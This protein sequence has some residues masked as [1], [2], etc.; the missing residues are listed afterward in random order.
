MVLSQRDETKATIDSL[1]NEVK[2][3]NTNFKKFEADVSFVKTG[4]NFLMKKS[5]EIEQQCWEN[6]QYSGRERLEIT[7]ISTSIPQQNLE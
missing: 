5:V 4:N 7:G 3:M 2:A 6:V 1:R